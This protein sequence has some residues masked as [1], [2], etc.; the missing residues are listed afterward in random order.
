[1]SV[2]L[3]DAPA[4]VREALVRVRDALA[5][6]PD[7]E[8]AVLYG[9]FV[10]GGYRADASDINLALVI[11]TDDLTKLVAPLRD[12][13]RAARIDPWIARATE[14][15]GLADAFATR[16]RDIQRCHHLLVGSDP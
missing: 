10:R 8:S 7:V 6:N 4:H 16:V 13:W 1:M 3:T 5:A 11:K 15:A 2:N 12:G 9:S 14:L